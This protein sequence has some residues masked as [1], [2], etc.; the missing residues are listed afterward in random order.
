MNSSWIFCGV[1]WIS[2]SYIYCAQYFNVSYILFYTVVIFPM[3]NQ[4]ICSISSKNKF[5]QFLS[6]PNIL[7]LWQM[8][9]RS[10]QLTMIVHIQCYHMQF[11]LQGEHLE[12]VARNEKEVEPGQKVTLGNDGTFTVQETCFMSLRCRENIKVDFLTQM[13]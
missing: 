1:V 7:L 5:L 4:E 11:S 12:C 3:L 6:F 8:L 10:N 9:N 2:T 13:T